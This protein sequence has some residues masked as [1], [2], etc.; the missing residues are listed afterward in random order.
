MNEYVPCKRRDPTAWEAI[1]RIRREEKE[2]RKREAQE[3]E[4]E[5]DEGRSRD[6]RV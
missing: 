2:R 6:A 5:A 4:R 1:G 3:K